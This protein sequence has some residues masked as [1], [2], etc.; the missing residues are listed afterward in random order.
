MYVNEEYFY[1]T[2]SRWLRNFIGCQY[3]AEKKILWGT[4]PD[5]IG[6]RFEVKKNEAIVS[7]H[8]AEV[9]I[10]NSSTSAY[11]LI[12]EMES[13]IASFCKHN[14]AF[15]ALYPYLGIY[16]AYDASEI[17]DYAANRGIGLLI[18]KDTGLVLKRPPNPIISNKVL[19]I[20]DLKGLK[21]KKDDEFRIISEVIKT[22]D[23]RIW[24]KIYL[25]GDLK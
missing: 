1:P 21:W 25:T 10:I 23:W 4:Q 5:V 8:L 7:L 2:I 17:K 3:T 22:L 16:E 18:V 20:N 12:G 9:K 24:E 13:R 19:N 15:Y 11:N 6:I 14:S